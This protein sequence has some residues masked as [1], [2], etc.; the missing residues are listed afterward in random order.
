MKHGEQLGN[1]ISEMKS[2]MTQLASI[3]SKVD[4]DD[5]IGVLLKS[6]P[7]EYDSLIR[8]NLDSKRAL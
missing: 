7:I 8:K 3:D 6:M 2:I 5:A 1:F 4:P